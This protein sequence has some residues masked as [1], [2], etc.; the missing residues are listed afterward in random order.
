MT[1]YVA[2]LGLPLEPLPDMMKRLSGEVISGWLLSQRCN[3]SRQ[4]VKEK[5]LVLIRVAWEGGVDG[6]VTSD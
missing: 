1:T 5:V 6:Q 4:M 2:W 3:A